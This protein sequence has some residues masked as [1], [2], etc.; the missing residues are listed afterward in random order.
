MNTKKYSI[1]IITRNRAAIIA[2][3]LNTVLQMDF[4]PDRFE[5]IVVDNG[6][7]DGTPRIIRSVLDGTHIDWKLV[8]EK[9]PGLCSARNTGI[10]SSVG[11]W[12]G[13]LDDDALVSSGWLKAYDEAMTR[14]PDAAAFGGP[15]TLDVRLQRPWWWCRKFDITMSCQDY[16]EE[17]MH[18]HPYTHPYGLNMLFNRRILDKYNG[19]DVTLDAIIPGLADETDLFYRM[20]K[21][22]EQLVYVPASRVIHSVLPDR[23]HWSAFS[24]R[25]IQVGRT[26]ACLDVRHKTRMH[27]SLPRRIVSALLETTVHPTPALVIKECLEWYGYTSFKK[28]VIHLLAQANATG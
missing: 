2:N 7:S 24:K 23:L 6:S 14:Y 8:H 10:A 17:L 11:Q 13:F 9:V 20:I 3:V 12:V 22:N 16:G 15:A 4:D 25:C 5:L 1:I 19:F 18:Y 27:R 26:F 21:N 28:K